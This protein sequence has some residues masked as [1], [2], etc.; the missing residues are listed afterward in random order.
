ME[1]TIKWVI[2]AGSGNGGH[3]VPVTFVPEMRSGC[4]HARLPLTQG[5]RRSDCLFLERCKITDLDLETDPKLP[6]AP[7]VVKMQR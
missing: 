7:W 1:S 2:W 5:V 4:R 6:S 3:N